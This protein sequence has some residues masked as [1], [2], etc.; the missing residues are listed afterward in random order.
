MGGM[1]IGIFET[2]RN[3]IGFFVKEG[4]HLQDIMHEKGLEVFPGRL[5]QCG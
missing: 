5:N 2:L 1:E 4:K 3:T